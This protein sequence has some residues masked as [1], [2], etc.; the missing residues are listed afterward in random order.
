[1]MG[2]IPYLTIIYLVTNKCH[3]CK[4]RIYENIRP[5]LGEAIFSNVDL[6]AK[7]QCMFREELPRAVCEYPPNIT[8]VSNEYS[9]QVK[10]LYH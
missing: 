8:T 7:T 5:F 1:M 4:S 9:I 3:T 10:C 2:K 6:G